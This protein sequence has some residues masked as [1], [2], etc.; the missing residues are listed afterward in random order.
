M[1]QLT[2]CSCGLAMYAVVTADEVWTF[3]CEHCDGYDPDADE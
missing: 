1:T 3:M 2:M